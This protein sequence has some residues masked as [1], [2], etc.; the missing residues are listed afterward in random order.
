MTVLAEIKG[1][2]R[3]IEVYPGQV[4][5]WWFVPVQTGRFNDLRCEIRGA[6]GVSHADHGMRGEIVIE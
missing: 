1:A 2:L 5:E 3:E 4:A 6:D